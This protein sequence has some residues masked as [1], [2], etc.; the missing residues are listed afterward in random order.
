MFRI[1]PTSLGASF[2]IFAVQALNSFKRV[3]SDKEKEGEVFTGGQK[4]PS[5]ISVT[6]NI[7]NNA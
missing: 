3:E 2:Y 7:L 6:P 4:V 5:G 1:D